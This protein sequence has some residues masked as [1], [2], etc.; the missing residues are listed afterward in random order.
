VKEGVHVPG[1]LQLG[2]DRRSGLEVG[3]QDV[4]ADA[5]P[6]D[7]A[8]LPLRGALCPLQ[9]ELAV[10]VLECQVWGRHVND[11]R[12]S[13]AAYLPI[14]SVDRRH[15]RQRFESQD[16]VLCRFQGSAKRVR[17]ALAV[18]V[19]IGVAVFAE[20]QYGRHELLGQPSWIGEHVTRVSKPGSTE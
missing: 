14:A 6:V 11:V 10:D 9:E 7:C 3:E 1:K 20:A 4:G 17:V 2:D 18:E 5:A 12:M 16:E 19:L 13:G 8:V 15:G